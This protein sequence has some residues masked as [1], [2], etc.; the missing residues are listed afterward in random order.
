M[1]K[2]ASILLPFFVAGVANASFTLSDNGFADG[3][4]IT[5]TG[6]AAELVTTNGGSNTFNTITLGGTINFTDATSI[7]T[8]KNSAME[9]SSRYSIV[10]ESGSSAN[11]NL[12]NGST[13]S[14]TVHTALNSFRG[15]LNISIEENAGGYIYT[16]RVTAQNHAVSL[17]LD[18]DY[19]IRESDI[20]KLFAVTLVTTMTIN[21]SADQAV[22]IDLRSGTT[23]Q[24][25]ITNNANL[26]IESILQIA[27]DKTSN[28]KLLNS[29]E[30][31]AL[32]FNKDI[33]A[34]EYQD[35]MIVIKK[36]DSTQ[37]L[38][39]KGSDGNLLKDLF[40]SDEVVEGYYYLSAVAPA[41]PEPAEFAVIFGALAL[42][43]SIYRK[44]K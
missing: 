24:L 29:L 19:A 38:N 5:G 18:K 11:I 1:K 2:I 3:T 31:G 4:L 22:K 12:L 39:I 20:N 7:S 27:S 32:L 40:W 14:F 37:T 26:Y 36:D 33:I 44:R 21:M 41:V 6:S 15:P 9:T 8:I 17:T 42:A 23:L 28:I 34:S 43:V 30:N 16:G 13:G 25:N 10:A 35:G